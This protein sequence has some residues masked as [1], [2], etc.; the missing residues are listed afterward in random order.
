[1]IGNTRA[2]GLR[3]SDEW[4]QEASLRLTGNKHLLG[5]RHS[6]EAKKKMSDAKIGKPRPKETIAKSSAGRTRWNIVVGETIYFNAA[7]A[8]A[9]LGISSSGVIKRCESPNFPNYKRIPKV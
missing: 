6:D 2:L 8:A 3:H 9:A 5:H 4:K 1:M 7:Q